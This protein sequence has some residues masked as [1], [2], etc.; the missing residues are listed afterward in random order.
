[1][2]FS[3]E[4]RWAQILQGMIYSHFLWQMIPYSQ[5]KIKKKKSLSGVSESSP[6]VFTIFFATDQ[7]DTDLFFIES[8]KI[9]TLAG[10][11]LHVFLFLLSMHVGLLQINCA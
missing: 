5:N 8:F 6:L 1:M 11:H 2:L 9:K 7:T 10:T 3:L 4:C